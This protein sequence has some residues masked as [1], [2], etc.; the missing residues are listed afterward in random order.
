M[1]LGAL[2]AKY[3]VRIPEL[4]MLNMEY[5]DRKIDYEIMNTQDIIR[6]SSTLCLF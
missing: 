5:I 3:E 2:R 6:I 4:K 1:E